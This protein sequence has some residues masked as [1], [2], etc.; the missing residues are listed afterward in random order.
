MSCLHVPNLHHQMQLKDKG[1]G[2]WELHRLHPGSTHVAMATQLTRGR[3]YVYGSSCAAS[4]LDRFVSSV[5]HGVVGRT[6]QRQ[7]REVLNLILETFVVLMVYSLNHYY[8]T[9]I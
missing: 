8:N 1:E 4:L 9:I 7:S 3:S 6:C 2:Q 5:P